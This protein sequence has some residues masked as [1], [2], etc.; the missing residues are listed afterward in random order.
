MSHSSSTARYTHTTRIMGLANVA[1]IFEF[2]ASQLLAI[3]M[4]L[5]TTKLV[6]LSKVQYIVIKYLMWEGDTAHTDSTG[7]YFT[8]GEH[9]PRHGD[10]S[11]PFQKPLVLY[12]HARHEPYGAPQLQ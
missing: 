9:L 11:A 5:G 4:T 8:L 1:N 2:A 10:Q 6:T 12:R 7:I 3:W